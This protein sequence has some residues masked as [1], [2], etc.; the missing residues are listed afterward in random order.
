MVQSVSMTGCD[1]NSSAKPW[2]V[3]ERTSKVVYAEF[4]EQV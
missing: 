1:L 3:Q 4:H 2:W